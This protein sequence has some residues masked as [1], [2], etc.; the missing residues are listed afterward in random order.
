M[1]KYRLLNWGMV[2]VSFGLTGILIAVA[3]SQVV[4]HFKGSGGADSWSSRTGLLLEPLLLLV[5]AFICDRISR[6]RRR[7]DGLKDMPLTTFGEW[8]L[9][10]ACFVILVVFSLLQLYQIG[11]L[12]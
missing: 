11:W 5:I 3:P 1:K 4:M 10:A 9:I 8:R 12:H 2:V 7:R 6:S